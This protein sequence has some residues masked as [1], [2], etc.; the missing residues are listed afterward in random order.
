[1]NG[2][3]TDSRLRSMFN[4][5]NCNYILGALSFSFCI[6]GISPPPIVLPMVMAKS[7]LNMVKEKSLA[8]EK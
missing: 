4:G 2:Q 7:A 5:G 6:S 1:M 8:S 3:F